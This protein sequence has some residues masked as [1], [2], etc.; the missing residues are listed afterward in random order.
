MSVDSIQTEAQYIAQHRAEP[1]KYWRG[2]RDFLE[3][4]K[5]GEEDHRIREAYL[6]QIKQLIKKGIAIPMRFWRRDPNT[7]RLRMTMSV[8]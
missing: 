2:S 4:M 6:K 7:K 1:D 5:R 8:T 3:S